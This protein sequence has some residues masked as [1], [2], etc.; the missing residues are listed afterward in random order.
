MTGVSHIDGSNLHPA[1]SYTFAAPL[2]VT[3][4]LFDFMFRGS[5]PVQNR[6]RLRGKLEDLHTGGHWVTGSK[7]WG[8]QVRDNSKVSRSV[9]QQCKYIYNPK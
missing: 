3:V 4:N 5:D 7:A 6:G 9:M 1:S 8:V 2:H